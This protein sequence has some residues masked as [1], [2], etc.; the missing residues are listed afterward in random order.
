MFSADFSG[1]L[2]VFF[3]LCILVDLKLLRNAKHNQVEKMRKI[4]LSHGT[5]SGLQG[6][7]EGY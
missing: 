2:E 3:S 1:V 4:F 7:Q 6:P 5:S